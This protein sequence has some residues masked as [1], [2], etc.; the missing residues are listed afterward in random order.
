MKTEKDQTASDQ[1]MFLE[2]VTGYINSQYRPALTFNQEKGKQYVVMT[3]QEI[4]LGLS[5][6]VDIELND[7]ADRMITLGYHTVIHDGKVGWLL[8]RLE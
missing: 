2:V 6:M 1:N 8:E 7:V 5:D 4:A 3:S